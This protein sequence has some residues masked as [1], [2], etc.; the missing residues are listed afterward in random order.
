[1]SQQWLRRC[2]LIVADASGSGL[3]LSG[4]RI[5]FQIKQ[6]DKETP[7]TAS[8]RVY[9]LADDT[10]NKIQKEFT[11][12]VLQAGYENGAFGIIFS[13][14]IKQ[15]RKGRENS[16]DSYIDIL[17]ADGDTFSNYAI[18]NYS[19]A[20]G[21][22]PQGRVAAACQG[23]SIGYVPGNLTGPTLPR[24]KVVCGMARDELHTQA[25][26]N[27][28]TY[29]IQNGQIVFLPLNGY[30]PNEAVV[31]NAQTG[32]IG[33]PEQTENG[34]KVRTLLN[35]QLEIGCK[36]QIDN[37]SI[38]IA[39]AAP[40]FTALQGIDSMSNPSANPLQAT[41][42]LNSDGLYRIY[43]IESVGDTRGNDWYND[44]ICLSIDGTVPMGLT[45][46]G[47]G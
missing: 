25:A 9:N 10:V 18:L 14:T 22:T 35:P 33:W 23:V 30:R 31:V 19:L 5:K 43:V 20:A 15:T 46:K 37:A 13:G 2:S 1:M 21:S 8:I 40:Q 16:I 17:G 38:L 4:L 24:G 12:V 6:A 26:T 41:V 28:L 3:D 32:M 47:Q 27:G 36:L 11:Q 39:P 42:P 7:Q 45:S 29:S 34:I 44:I